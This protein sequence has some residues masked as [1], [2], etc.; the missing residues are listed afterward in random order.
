MGVH[1]ANTQSTPTGLRLPLS[2][3]VWLVDNGSPSQLA[4]TEG[5][6]ANRNPISQSSLSVAMPPKRNRGRTRHRVTKSESGAKASSYRILTSLI[7]LTPV[8]QSGVLNFEV[9]SNFEVAS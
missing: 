9:V 2:S 8:S 4:P 3:K 7:S 1:R 6:E 5:A